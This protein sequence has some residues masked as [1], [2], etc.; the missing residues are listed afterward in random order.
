MNDDEMHVDRWALN[1]LVG[2]F[3]ST[4]ERARLPPCYQWSLDSGVGAL[5]NEQIFRF[6]TYFP[7]GWTFPPTEHFS[8]V[9]LICPP[10]LKFIW[11][12]AYANMQNATS[13]A[14]LISFTLISL[15]Q[16]K[17]IKTVCNKGRIGGGMVEYGSNAWAKLSNF[18]H[19]NVRIT[20]HQGP[21]NM[22]CF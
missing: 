5:I 16:I 18:K 10:N 6:S 21:F 2:W 9:V 7:E 22:S 13:L 17:D 4:L 3:C 14:S 19:W 1:V 20:V 11:G 12:F 8:I 15:G